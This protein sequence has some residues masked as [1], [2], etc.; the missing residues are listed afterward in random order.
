MPASWDEAFAEIERRPRA[1]HRR[2][3]PRR[4]RAVPRQPVRAQHRR[5]PLRP[6]SARRSA[7]TTSTRRRTV[8]QMP[9]QRGVRLMFGDRLASPVPDIDRT[10]L[11]LILGA[12]PLA[13]NGSLMTAPDLPGRLRAMQRA[14]RPLVVIDPRR[15][16]TAER[17][18]P[19]TSPIRPGS[20]A[21]PA[22]RHRARRC[23]PS[24]CVR[25]GRLAEH[26]AGLDELLEAARAD[27]APERR[28]P[29]GAASPPTSSAGSRASSR[30]RRARRRVRRAS[31]PAR[32]SSVRSRAGSSTCST[33]SPATSTSRAGRCS[34][35]RPR[36][37]AHARHAGA[38]Q[39]RP[40]RPAAQPG[41]AAARGVRRA[42]DRAR[43]PRRSRRRATGRSAR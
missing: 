5:Q 2:A 17:G 36:S 40:H 6:V 28:R 22:A 30:P 13:S 8:D 31:A 15:T 42:A 9:K 37:R 19:S 23:S 7:R 39:G 25:L 21:L 4:G 20:D 18:R 1:D 16:A 27:F 11:L 38:R 32:R 43:S 14:R 12:D 41:R 26:V 10:D 29:R 35:G 3:W 24:G 34:R 33:C